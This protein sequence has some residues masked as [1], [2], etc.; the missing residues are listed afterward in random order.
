MDNRFLLA[1]ALAILAI[2]IGIPRKRKGADWGQFCVRILALPVSGLFLVALVHVLA[3]KLETGL[4]WS[5]LHWFNVLTPP[6]SRVV[7]GVPVLI[8][9]ISLAGTLY[10][11]LMGRDLHTATREW[12]TRLGA[13]VNIY[14]IASA[15]LFLIAFGARGL[16]EDVLGPLGGS[17]LASGWIGTTLGG[18]MAGHGSETGGK[19]SSGRLEILAQVAPYV[20]VVGLL[21]CLSYAI[22]VVGRSHFGD[23]LSILGAVVG[24]LVAALLLSWRVNINDFSMYNFYRNRL[25]RCYLGASN[26]NRDAHPFTG[27]DPNEDQI[28]MQDLVVTPKRRPPLAADPQAGETTNREPRIEERPYIGP[29]FVINTALNLMAGENLAW[30][31]RMAT[32]F[33]ISPLF[34]GFDP[35]GPAQKVAE[36]E[37]GQ[38][39]YIPTSCYEDGMPIGAA[40][41]ISGAAV[42]PNMGYHS[43]APLAFLMTV[44]NVRLGRWIGNPKSAKASRPGPRLGLPYL[45]VELFGMTNAKRDYVYLSDGGHFENL[46]IYELVRRRCRFIVACDAEDDGQF[47]FDALGNAIEKCRTDFGVNIKIDVDQIRRS[48]EKPEEGRHCAVGSIDYG[49]GLANGTLLYIK[50]SLTGDEPTDVKRYRDQNPAFPHQTTLDQAF[51]ETQFE[52]YRA[53]GEHIVTTVLNAVGDKGKVKKMQTEE[54]FVRLRRQW[55]PPAGG[56]GGGRNGTFTQHAQE[57]EKLLDKISGTPHLRFL[58]SQLNPGLRNLA[59]DAQGA[60]KHR[61]WLPETYLE[62]RAGYYIC[63][64]MIQLMENVYLDLDLDNEWDHPDNQG[65]KNLFKNWSWAGMFRATWALTASVY[66]SRFRDFCERR[67][68]LTIGQVRLGKAEHLTGDGVTLDTVLRRCRTKLLLNFVE[69]RFLETLVDHLDKSY[70]ATVY[71][72]LVRV[73]MPMRPSEKVDIAVGFALVQNGELMFLRIQD[74][75][76][77]MGLARRAVRCLIDKKIERVGRWPLEGE[78]PVVLKMAKIDDEIGRE[79]APGEELISQEIERRFR[80][81]FRSVHNEIGQPDDDASSGAAADS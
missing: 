38:K 51:D 60:P 46:G 56:A 33:S 55:H 42:S 78:K 16:F 58:D 26:Q 3:P 2:F 20:F 21:L 34:S 32:S 5:P 14:S 22:D 7:W 19:K 25:T 27:F 29:Y 67:L 15:G 64:R 49:P 69:V 1:G 11:G 80:I 10:I 30:Q 12:W 52:S 50:S 77:A 71:P 40:A 8:V 72:I 62:L 57:Y 18:L 48:R 17:L 41:T 35:S 70:P 59:K 76:R 4:N 79:Q 23:P 75:L 61:F 31:K 73:A 28:R 24:C 9:L 74:H 6:E 47:Q 81:F 45:L 66:G 44:F 65:W 63:A 39:G 53:L 37:G 68:E 43:S 36:P 54:L 13:W